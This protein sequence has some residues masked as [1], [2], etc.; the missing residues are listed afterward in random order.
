MEINFLNV[1]CL[2]LG[3]ILSTNG[4]LENKDTEEE[5]GLNSF[6]DNGG[7]CLHHLWNGKK[8]CGD[9]EFNDE[10]LEEKFVYFPL[11]LII[12]KDCMTLLQNNWLHWKRFQRELPLM[13][14]WSIACYTGDIHNDFNPETARKGIDDKSYLYYTLHYFLTKA[15]KTL[16]EKQPR[17]RRTLYRGIEAKVT[18]CKIGMVTHFD[19]FGSTSESL[20]EA[21]K[22]AGKNGT[23]FVFKDTSSGV[24]IAKYSLHEEEREYLYTSCTKFRVFKVEKYF[25]FTKV[26]L[27]EIYPD[28]TSCQSIHDE[29]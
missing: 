15:Y 16:Y 17:V 27:R 7:T 9:Y 28:T 10:T 2:V 29:F 25:N 21:M 19:N 23:I 1:L 5:I 13:Q 4:E 20:D 12:Y 22:F 24:D 18:S 3:L 14:H 11:D 8:T 26:Y 6:H